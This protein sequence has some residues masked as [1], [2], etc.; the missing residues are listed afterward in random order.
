[1]GI[2]FPNGFSSTSD[3]TG[4]LL[5]G[6]ASDGTYIYSGGQHD[7]PNI[8]DC[9]TFLHSDGIPFLHK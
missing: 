1:M 2:E 6:L 5:S 8:V 4:I 7:D 3:G 9:S